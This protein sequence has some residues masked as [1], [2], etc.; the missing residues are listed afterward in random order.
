VPG[1]PSRSS[2]MVS[3]VSHRSNSFVQEGS[4][5]LRAGSAIEDQ[6][7]VDKNGG[8]GRRSSQCLRKLLVATSSF[9][10]VGDDFFPAQAIGIVHGNRLDHPGH[11]FAWNSMRTF[12][13]HFKENLLGRHGNL[14]PLIW[15]FLANAS[16]IASSSSKRGGMASKTSSPSMNSDGT[17]ARRWAL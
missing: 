7:A 2:R 17:G 11:V 9:Q 5:L 3:A 10:C 15:L 14:P 1:S 8:H 13:Q 12:V 4:Q 6:L 16:S